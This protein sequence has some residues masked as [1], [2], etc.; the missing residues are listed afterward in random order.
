CWPAAA[1]LATP[2]TAHEA[3]GAAASL[4]VGKST[5]EAVAEG[6]AAVAVHSVARTGIPGAVRP[7]V[8]DAVGGADATERRPGGVGG[9][10]ATVE[11][12]ATVAGEAKAA[13]RIA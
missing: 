1:F 7:A 5:G 4:A 8:A 9:T 11:V 3:R 12:A 6:A 2:F 13:P 10:V